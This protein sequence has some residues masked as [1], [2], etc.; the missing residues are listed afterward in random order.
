[1]DKLIGAIVNNLYLARTKY[2]LVYIVGILVLLLGYIIWGY[3]TVRELFILGLL[4]TIPSAFLECNQWS[5]TSRWNIFEHSMSIPIKVNIIARYL[6]PFLTSVICLG[7]VALFNVITLGHPNIVDSSIEIVGF[8]DLFT[9]F[10][11]MNLGITTYYP[12]VYAMNPKKDGTSQ[13]ILVLSYG[14]AVVY[15]LDWSFLVCG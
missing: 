2:M 7:L 6:L 15:L 8:F 14:L 4:V 12:I 1:M 10:I 13:I 5:F 9:W 3:G 11:Y